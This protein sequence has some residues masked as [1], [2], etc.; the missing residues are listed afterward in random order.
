MAARKSIS[1][2]LR[3]EVFKR[4]K[5]TCQYCGQSAPGV[6][7]E[8]DHIEPVSKGGSNSILNLLTSCR[9]CNSGKRDRR[10]DDESVLAKQRNAMAEMEER[11]QQIELMA[12]W[13]QDMHD[14]HEVE[15]DALDSIVI[16]RTD[17]E[18]SPAGRDRAR[19]WIKKYGINNVL[20][21]ANDCFDRHLEYDK[22]GRVSKKSFEF[23]FSKIVGIANLLKQAE[24]KPYIPKL[25]YIQGIIRN[26]IRNPK[27]MCIEYLEH[28][29][30]AGMSLEEIQDAAKEIEYS[31][32]EFEKQF[33]GWLDK[34]GNPY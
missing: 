28:I 2:K 33:D 22:D 7:L 21:A 13:H 34:I 17:Y 15:I 27:F 6:I 1:K 25:A 3:F 16:R 24:E 11:R 4:D 9:S 12:K 8:V 29:H 14:T 20:A 31:F 23:A 19:K 26:R 32:S 10:L 30:L 18:L 5:F